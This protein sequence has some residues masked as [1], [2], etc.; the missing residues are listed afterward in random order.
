MRHQ[1]HIGVI[2]C[3]EARCDPETFTPASVY[4]LCQS[5]PDQDKQWFARLK[6]EWREQRRMFSF[7]EDMKGCPAYQTIIENGESFLPFIL[8]DVG[9]ADPDYWFEALA[10]ITGA[11][12]VTE[13]MYGDVPR[14]ADAWLHWA[15]MNHVRHSRRATIF[16]SAEPTESSGH[17]SAVSA[18]QLS[19]VGTWERPT[20]VRSTQVSSVAPRRSPRADGGSIFPV[21]SQGQLR[22]VQGWIVGG[23]IRESSSIRC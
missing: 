5:H 3:V 11:D 8:N 1:R 22:E 7:F 13:D 4:V 15:R 23:G 16:S 19:C 12:P 14:M 6:D 20:E 18:L 2:H 21:S 17:E 9:A 10:Q